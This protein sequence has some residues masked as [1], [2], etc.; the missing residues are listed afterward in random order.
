LIPLTVVL[1]LILVLFLA[2]FA[3]K[4]LWVAAAILL[5]LWLVGFLARG[6]ERARWYRW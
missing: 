2:G 6:T 1:V 4:A 5:A 3:I